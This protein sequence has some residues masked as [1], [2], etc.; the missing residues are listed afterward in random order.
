MWALLIEPANTCRVSK[1]RITMELF[2]SLSVCVNVYY[3]YITDITLVLVG[4][5]NLSDSNASE[6]KTMEGMGES[7]ES[8]PLVSV[9][10][11]LVAWKEKPQT[12]NLECDTKSRGWIGWACARA[13][14]TGGRFKIGPTCW[15]AAWSTSSPRPRLASS[16]SAS[17]SGFSSARKISTWVKM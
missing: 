12:K 2:F 17:S 8:A 10:W 11:V 7:F 4:R 5:E 3:I 15:A 9:G 1:E 14:L 6:K 16:D 13:L